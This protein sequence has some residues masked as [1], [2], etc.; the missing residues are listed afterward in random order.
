MT[1]PN[2]SHEVSMSNVIALGNIGIDDGITASAFKSLLDECNPNETLYLDVHSEGG[3][4]FEG[5]GIYQALNEWTGHKVARIKSAAFS[6]AS[7]IVMACD[8]IEI[9]E[10]GYFMVHNP[11][12]VTEGDESEH[13]K[14]AELLR[15]L[16]ASMM[17]AYCKRTHQTPEQIQALLDDESYLN[18]QRSIALGF[19]DRVIETVKAKREFNNKMPRLVFASLFGA[20]ASGNNPAK[21][22]EPPMSEAK[23]VVATVKSIKA[24]Y[25]KASSDFIVRCMEKEMTDEEV[26]A[27]MEIELEEQNEEL[28]AKVRAMEEELAAAK[29]QIA[30][31]A[32]STDDDKPVSAEEDEE[33]KEPVAQT[34]K[35]QPVAK[36]KSQ[37]AGSARNRWE[38]AVKTNLASGMD[39]HRALAKANRDNPGLREQM[40]V[41]ANAS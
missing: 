32:E 7:Y 16:K 27:E 5:F 31:K 1:P 30:A 4:V 26:R 23:K 34:K 2:Y 19:A 9:A 3:S 6:I 10:N 25:P 21:P 37:P 14:S 38:A 13:A 29:A 33:E 39:R 17:T 8:E 11:W 28:V 36:P 24:A 12:S 18:A 20:G 35:T 40:I 22:K 15:D 41:E